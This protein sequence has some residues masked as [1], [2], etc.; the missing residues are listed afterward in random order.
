M[1]I[2]DSN[3]ES[4]AAARPVV[5]VLGVVTM[6]RAMF[7]GVVEGLTGTKPKRFHV[8]DM[9]H[10]PDQAHSP[11]SA[12]SAHAAQAGPGKDGGRFRSLHPKAIWTILKDAGME[13]ME[14]K[15]PR[16]G[17]ALAYYTIFSLAPLLVIAIGIAGFIMGKSDA[18]REHVLNQIRELVGTQGGGA[19]QTMIEN[20]SKPGQGILATVLGIIMLLFGAMGLFGQLQDALNTVWEVQPKP[21]RGLWGIIQDRFLSLTMVLGTAF[22]LL[23]SLLISAAIAAMAGVLGLGQASAI[24]HIINI[25]VSLIVIT[26]LFAMIYRFLPDAKVA[27]KDVWLGAAITA[28][29]FVIGK[30]LLGLDLGHSAVGSTYGAAGSF[31]VLLI[32]VYYAAQIFL[33]GAEFTQ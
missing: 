19:V 31:A 1:A 30:F 14:D 23:V 22:L 24:G 25:V 27:W 32:W 17:A 7:A 13:W 11:T 5:A 20:A 12:P 21:G 9:R 18:A 6:A 10:L 2:R 8:A 33:Y 26:L 15:A 3:Q 28:L 29:L 4:S 16:L